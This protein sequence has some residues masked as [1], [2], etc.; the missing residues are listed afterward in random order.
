MISD[1]L[2][3]EPGAPR[4][5]DAVPGMAHFAGTGPDGTTCRNCEFYRFFRED[6]PRLHG[7]CK[8]YL[9][10]TGRHGPAIDGSNASCKYFE[11]VHK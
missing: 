5:R 2:T 3:H 8:K 1:Y 4:K 7:G 9:L 11:E 6:R 10:L